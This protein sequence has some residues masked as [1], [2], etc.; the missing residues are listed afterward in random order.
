VR[1]RCSSPLAGESTATT[2]P[3]VVESTTK[4]TDSDPGE[5]VT[6]RVERDVLRHRTECVV[7][8]GSEYDV[9]GGSGVEHYAG[10]VWVDTESFA[11]GAESSADFTITW[12]EGTA[13]SRA[14]LTWAAG[15]SAFDVTLSV[16]TWRDGEPFADRRWE[17]TFERDLT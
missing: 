13:R 4:S 6:W 14:E 5:G 17:R 2:D 12:P 15:A 8:H 11:Q 1:R 9:D 7:D 3:L 10:T 16:Q